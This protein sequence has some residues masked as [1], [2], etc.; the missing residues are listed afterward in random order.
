MIGPLTGKG[1]VVKKTSSWSSISTVSTPIL[2]FI[3]TN[4]GFC[5][6]GKFPNSKTKGRCLIVKQSWELN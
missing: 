3:K 4:L 6:P 5:I 1:G 2:G